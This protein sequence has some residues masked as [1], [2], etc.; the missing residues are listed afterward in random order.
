MH[1]K[2]VCTNCDTLVQ[3]PVPAHVIDKGMPSTSIIYRST[4]KRASL[5]RKPYV[6]IFYLWNTARKMAGLAEVRMHDLRHSFA[7]LLINSGR[8]LYEVQRLL[9]R[10]QVKTTQR[11]T[12]T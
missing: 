9:G 5:P 4:G 2:W 8:T 10:P 1:G 11:P 3:A 7:S 12:R 6:A